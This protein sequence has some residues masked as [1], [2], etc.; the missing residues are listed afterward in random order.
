MSSR[1]VWALLVALLW[2]GQA[3]AWHAPSHI[4]DFRGDLVHQEA[5]CVLGVNGHGTAVSSRPEVSAFPGSSSVP[6]PAR[7]S[8]HARLADLSLLPPFRGPPVSVTYC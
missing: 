2:A 1:V 6:L 4:D 8:C 5:D 3:Q 7:P